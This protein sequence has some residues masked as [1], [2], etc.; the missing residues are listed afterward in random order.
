VCLCVL[1]QSYYSDMLRVVLLIVL[2]SYGFQVQS[3]S[4]VSRALNARTRTSVDYGKIST[5]NHIGSSL[6]TKPKHAK[7]ERLS[8]VIGFASSM[9][10]DNSSSDAPFIQAEGSEFPCRIKVI[11]VGGGGGNAVN[12]MMESATAIQGVEMWAVNTDAQALSKNH[13]TRKLI[14]GE[15]SSR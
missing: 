1:P 3:F 14:I 6:Y 11:G 10:V 15:T 7:S 12:R 13:A 8:P 9:H 4:L 2:V 5:N